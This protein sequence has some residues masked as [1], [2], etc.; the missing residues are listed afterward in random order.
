MTIGLSGNIFDR[1]IHC[2]NRSGRLLQP[3]TKKSPN[4]PTESKIIDMQHYLPAIYYIKRN[5][6]SK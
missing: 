1:L 6:T 5:V 4:K 3:Y 2:I